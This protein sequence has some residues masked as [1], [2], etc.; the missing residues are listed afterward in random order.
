M[1]K[2]V[3]ALGGGGYNLTTVPR[4]WTLAAAQLVGVPLPNETPYAFGGR[5]SIP[6]L[7]DAARP[8]ISARDAR[9]AFA[10]AERV[11]ASIQQ[12]IFPMHGLRPAG[13]HA[14]L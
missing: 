11:I 12:D 14:F 3:L 5:A 6:T 8:T 2:P 7:L 13:T 9:A 4:M 10:A 1:G